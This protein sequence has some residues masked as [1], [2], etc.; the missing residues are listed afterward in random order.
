VAIQMS[1]V[2]TSASCVTQIMA[3]ARTMAVGKLI[4]RPS[5]A[6]CRLLRPKPPAGFAKR[7]SGRPVG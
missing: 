4:R 2:K 6:F 7:A 1:A 5:Q 3:A